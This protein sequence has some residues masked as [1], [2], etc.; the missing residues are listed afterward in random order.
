MINDIKIIIIV[1]VLAG[2]A[3]LGYYGYNSILEH[4]KQQARIECLEEKQKY[5]L[6]V[7][8]KIQDL[9][10]ALQQTA[11]QGE[12]KKQELGKTIRDIKS[13]LKEQPITIIEN[14]K[15]IPAVIFLD[16][17]NEAIFKANQQ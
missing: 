9:E 15:C 3:L 7:K 11:E 4:G 16:S 13:K 12:R 8:Q 6:E 14:G 5:E 1:I 17:I 10:I 2:L